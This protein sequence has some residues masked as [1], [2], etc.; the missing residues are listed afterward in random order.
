MMSAPGFLEVVEPLFNV[1][2]PALV[3]LLLAALLFLAALSGL[4]LAAHSLV[5]FVSAV[6]H[7]AHLIA[8]ALAALQRSARAWRKAGQLP[9]LSALYAASVW[10]SRRE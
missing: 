2:S 3:G 5:F 8:S 9:T 7:A 10:P 6:R 1:F 4:P